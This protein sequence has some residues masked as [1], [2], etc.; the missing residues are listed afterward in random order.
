MI[1]RLSAL[2]SVVVDFRSRK[3]WKGKKP[4]RLSKF[5]FVLFAVVLVFPAIASAEGLKIGVVNLNQV[6]ESYNKRAELEESFKDI[7]VQE[8]DLLR[9]KQ[10]GLI[11]LREE[12]Q[13]MEKGSAARKELETELEKKL[14]Y[15][16]LEEEVAR[17]NLGAKEREYYEELYRDIS[18]AIEEIGSE[19][20]FDIILKKEV[21]QPKSADL[22]ELRLKIGMGTVLYYSGAVDITDMIVKYLNEK[23]SG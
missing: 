18:A 20:G 13:L 5:V 14:L 10:D 17:K 7:Q 23:Y 12:I 19:Q 11:S 22:L 3:F 6:F 4:M 1:P 8:E 16:Q 2:T 9:E 15:L 21:L